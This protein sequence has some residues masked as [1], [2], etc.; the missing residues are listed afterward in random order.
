[1]GA[2]VGAVLLLVGAAFGRA[3]VAVLAGPL[4]GAALW[5]WLRTPSRDVEVSVGAR[6]EA[7]GSPDEAAGSDGTA[8]SDETVPRAGVAAGD[9]PGTLRTHVRVR[10]PRDTAGVALAVRRSN[11]SQD[12]VVVQVRGTRTVPLVVRTVRT[13]PQTVAEVD[14]IGIGPGGTS[15]SEPVEPASDEA[16]VLPT[17]GPLA[18]LPLPHRL[19]GLSGAHPS[20]RP[21]E[22]GGLRDVHPYAPGD[23][24]RRIDWRVTARRSPRLQELYVRRELALAEAVVLLVVDSRDDVGPDPR[25]WRGSSRPRATDP[26]SLD[27]ARQAATSLAQ[28]YLSAGDR[29]GLDDLGAV[30]R[31]LPPGGGRRQLD[32]IRHALALTRPEG[33][34]LHRVRAPQLPSGALVVVFSTFLDDAAADAA[35]QWRRAGHRVVAVDVLPTLREA[36]LRDRERL[37]LRLVRLAR[38]D[39]LA[40]V[41]DADVELVSWR[42]APQVALAGLARSGQRRPGAG[43]GVR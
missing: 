31:P 38:T 26:T 42:D 29:V 9:E 30:R 4:V 13:G 7:D 1:M 43:A 2:A 12:E 18:Q 15:V 21:G 14:A 17:P 41:Q 6:D 19:R 36:A 10:A 23:R 39:R 11:R 3:D 40:A 34:P 20:R 37:A 35:V 32:R 25:T 33:E 16:L 28:A 22:G 27:L 5:G 24:L 8:G